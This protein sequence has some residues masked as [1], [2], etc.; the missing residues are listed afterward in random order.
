MSH[1]IEPASNDEALALLGSDDKPLLVDFFATWCG[2]CR[3]FSP[4][5]QEFATERA[6]AVNVLKIDVDQFTEIA[7]KA[8]I[9]SVPTLMVIK[10]GQV[11]A[12]QPGAL[13]K[14]DLAKFV[15][16]ALA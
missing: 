6:G 10:N 7:L 5:L 14:S 9:R 12:A 11:L 16:R 13:P 2:P 4:V 15:D 3:S 1:V 8:G